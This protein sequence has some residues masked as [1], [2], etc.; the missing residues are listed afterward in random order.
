MPSQ[1][2]KKEEGNKNSWTN[3]WI[4]I[5]LWP[6]ITDLRVE[7]TT[8]IYLL[9]TMDSRWVTWLQIKTSISQWM[10]CHTTR[11]KVSLQ[12]LTN[13]GVHRWRTG[14]TFR[15]HWLN[16]ERKSMLVEINPV[17]TEEIIPGCQV[18]PPVLRAASEEQA[19]DKWIFTK[20]HQSPVAS[21]QECLLILPLTILLLPKELEV[22]IKFENFQEAQM[23]EL[24]VK[25]WVLMAKNLCN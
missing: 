25:E 15:V 24:E 3:R 14:C 19:P 22:T 7:N 11:W 20:E 4:S 16:L 8:E 10:D 23:L 6:W 13:L 21:T 12:S 5:L 1:M 18:F 2:D 17:Q 9:K